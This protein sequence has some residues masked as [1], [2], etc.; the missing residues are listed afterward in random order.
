MLDAVGFCGAA[1]SAGL[2]AVEDLDG[3][4][5][6][7]GLSH[8]K[9]LVIGHVEMH[10][11]HRTGGSLI[12]GNAAVR[13]GPRH[14]IALVTLQQAVDSM[15]CQRDGPHRDSSNPR[16]CKSDLHGGG[17]R[18]AHDLDGE[19]TSVLRRSPHASGLVSVAEPR[20]GRRL[21]LTTERR[22]DG[23]LDEE[24]DSFEFLPRTSE[25][26]STVQKAEPH[27]DGLSLDAPLTTRVHHARRLAAPSGVRWGIARR[28]TLR[29][30][31]LRRRASRCGRQHPGRLRRR[32]ALL[33]LD[34][35]GLQGSYL[36]TGRRDRYRLPCRVRSFG[37][38]ADDGPMIPRNH[39]APHHTP[40]SPSQA[41]QARWCASTRTRVRGVIRAHLV[42]GRYLR[43]G[44]VGTPT[45]TGP[46]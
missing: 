13:G 23:G 27:D 38:P 20:R 2:L 34:P 36:P 18:Q 19:R 3:V 32:A 44:R 30:S 45:E 24:L 9:K 26:H 16:Y 42:R 41:C 15:H 31:S 39:P 43:L 7:D 8:P 21:A 5:V 17:L 12:Y 40:H 33:E 28:D 37:D 22:P 25:R 35:A 6:S 1:H 46:Q 10:R 29:I 4:E 11:P 14:P